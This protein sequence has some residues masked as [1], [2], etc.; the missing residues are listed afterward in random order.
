MKKYLLILISALA[1]SNISWRNPLPPEGMYPMSQIENIDLADAGLKISPEEIYNP[2][3]ISLIDALVNISGCTGSFVSQDGLILTNHHCAFRAINAASSTDKNYLE[4]GFLADTKEKEIPATGYKCRIT[5]SYEDVSGKILGAVK[6]VEDFGE[7]ARIINKMMDELAAEASDEKNS[8]EARVS[9]MF[10]G[11][12]YILFR[13][14]I[15]RDIRLVFAPPRS[16]GEFGGESDNWIWPR[17]TGDF[18]F[19]RAYVAPDGSAAEYSQDNVPYNPKKFLRINPAGVSEG[20]FV[21]ILGYPGRTYRHLPSQF[22]EFQQLYQLPYISTLFEWMINK[23]EE[24]GKTDPAL[25][26]GFASRI[27]SLANVMKN[28][29]GKMKGLRKLNLLE[30]KQNEEKMLKKMITEQPDLNGKYTGVFDKIE[31]VYRKKFEFG[32]SELWLREFLRFS[33]LAGLANF[34]WQN[35]EQAELPDSLRLEAFRNENLAKTLSR[36]EARLNEYNSDFESAFL[37]KMISDADLMNETNR[38]AAVDSLFENVLIDRSI[39]EYVSSQLMNSGLQDKDFLT[40]LFSKSP[41][42]LKEMDNPLLGLVYKIRNQSKEIEKKDEEFDGALSEL[43]PKLVEIK[44]QWQKKTFIPDANSTLR[45]TYGYIKG[46]SP[47]DA[48]RYSPV[49]SLEGVIEKSVNGGDYEIPSKLREL[50]EKKD[51]GDY[52]SEEVKGLPVAILYNTDTT[53]GNSGSPVF[54][55]SGELIGLNFDR[56]YEAT[57]NDFAW[58]DSYSRS[59]GVDIRYI[60]WV[61]EKIGGAE[62][63]INELRQVD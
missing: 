10:A 36:T 17:H 19:M 9:E 51:Y 61:T 5:E 18:S 39:D 8:I 53:G 45:L 6:G 24:I 30:K 50:Y 29:K 31:N 60:L 1:L 12:S 34:V 47:A 49:T 20:D 13:Y 63:I 2:N 46:Y 55:A 23:Y 38:I 57:I 52:Y 58:D 7:R 62:N 35:A 25:E 21:F 22:I 27:K 26:L 11:Q 43:L 33:T 28:Y 3:G 54:N 37:E 15:I 32:H 56:A 16:I 40:E 44:R 41:D 4:E 14:R 59:I 48:V 42:E